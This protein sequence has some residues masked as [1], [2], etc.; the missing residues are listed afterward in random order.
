MAV[1]IGGAGLGQFDVHGQGSVGSA[2]GLSV[3][4]FTGNVVAGRADQRL[5][6]QGLDLSLA[7]T[8]NSQGASDRSN[9]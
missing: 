4:A 7:R 2:S 3:N 1:I 5:I 9:P 6:S 8:Y